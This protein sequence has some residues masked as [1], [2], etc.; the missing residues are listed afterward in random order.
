MV[1][2]TLATV[3]LLCCATAIGLLLSLERPVV[4]RDTVLSALPWLF[5]AT[6]LHAIR[7]TISYPLVVEPAFAFPGILLLIGSL[8]GGAWLL[9]TQLLNGER[10]HRRVARFLGLIGIGTVVAP[11]SVTVATYGAGVPTGRLLAWAVTPVLA[12]LVTYLLLISLWVLLPRTAAFAG[13][14]G[15]LLLF[16]LALHAIIVA[17]AVAYGEW[18]SPPLLIAATERLALAIDVSETIA[19][20]WILVGGWLLVAVAAIAGFGLLRRWHATLGQR[21]FDAATVLSVIIG[22]NTFV[23]AL[24]RGVVV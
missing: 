22:S 19:L 17:F 4:T 14:T 20:V 7:G 18:T 21:G 23:V 2:L 15:A 8:W 16:G 9:V 11:F 1:T 10:P 5:L 6:L 13:F 3:V 12:C 24:V